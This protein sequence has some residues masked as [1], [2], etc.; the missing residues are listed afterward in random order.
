MP[1]LLAVAELQVLSVT[2]QEVMVGRIQAV[3]VAA[4]HITT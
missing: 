1:A 2:P 3:V 4:D